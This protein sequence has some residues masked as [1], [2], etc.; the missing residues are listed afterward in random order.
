[1]SLSHVQL[2][3]IPWTAAYQAPP[4]MGFSRQEYWSGVPSHIYLFISPLKPQT[5]PI[6]IFLILSKLT[7]SCLPSVSKHNM[8]FPV[9]QVPEKP[10]HFPFLHFLYAFIHI[11]TLTDHLLFARPILSSLGFFR[12]KKKKTKIPTLERNI[13]QGE[14]NWKVNIIIE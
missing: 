4:S 7:C 11:L 6:F 3:A 1:M 5:K 12:E 2:L 9:N 10:W 14:R 8:R 13:S